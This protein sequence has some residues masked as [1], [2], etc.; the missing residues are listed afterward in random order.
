[1]K[2]KKVKSTRLENIEAKTSILKSAAAIICAAAVCISAN[3]AVGKYSEAIVKSAE[4]KYSAAKIT[5]STE[6]T[7]DNIADDIQNDT[8]AKAV[9]SDD[10]SLSADETS[11]E[12]EA[13]VSADKTADTPA[14][15]AKS[16]DPTKYSTAQIVEY[17]NTCLKNTYKLPKLTI[18]KTEDIKIVIDD[19]TPGGDAMVNLG[20][21]IINRYAKAS[22]YTGT[23][24]N[25]KSTTG[26]DDA[27]EFS[28][29][30]NL[31]A[32]GAKT[33]SVKKSGSGY[34]INITVVPEKATLEKRPVYNSQCV[35]P[36][37]IGSV[38][39]F[40]LKITQ[41]DFNYP[42]TTLKAVVDA[43][44]RVTSARTYMPMNGT[45]AGKL[46]ITGGATVHGSMT[47]SATFIF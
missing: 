2:E 39:L 40:G 6:G 14:G 26:G 30:A 47:K 46:I 23:F 44:G 1:M 21:K 42:A 41:A 25:G 13:L 29:H 45:G 11:A 38:D 4:S 5:E 9:S 32:A 16:N 36:L 22:D 31:V 20:N 18:K 27:Q 24:A 37:D 35:N 33:A 17:Y 12:S 15:E 19:I 34:E 10:T 28:M 7:A 43:G 3:S 8:A